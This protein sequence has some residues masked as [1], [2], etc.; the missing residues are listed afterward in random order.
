VATAAQDAMAEGMSRS[1]GRPSPRADGSNHVQRR[2]IR[3]E[4][5]IYLARSQQYIVDVQRLQG[6]LYLYFDLCSELLR[7]LAARSNPAL[8]A[9]LGGARALANASN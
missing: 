5:Q 6:P 2:L 9:H 8:Q 7:F 4:V 3:F 1:I